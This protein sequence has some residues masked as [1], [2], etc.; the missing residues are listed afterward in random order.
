[1][2]NPYYG[3]IDFRSCLCQEVDAMKNRPGNPSKAVT[4]MTF[5]LIKVSILAYY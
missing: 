2:I 5:D 1:M 3:I 4:G